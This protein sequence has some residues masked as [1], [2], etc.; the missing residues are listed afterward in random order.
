MRWGLS[1]S[2][3]S[4][5]VWLPSSP[6]WELR[7]VVSASCPSNISRRLRLHSNGR[8]RRR[9]SGGRTS[10]SIARRRG[11][12]GCSRRRAARA[13]SSRGPR[14]RASIPIR[15]CASVAI[16]TSGSRGVAKASMPCS[17]AWDC[18]PNRARTTMSPRVSIILHRAT[19]CTCRGLRTAYRSRSTTGLRRATGIR[20]ARRASC[21][22]WMMR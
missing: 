14:T 21:A 7:I 18:C 3:R 10:S 6:C 4:S 11:L 13:P 17:V 8:A 12:P 19:T 9:P 16:S 22:F 20:S 1:K 5:T 2:G 15:S